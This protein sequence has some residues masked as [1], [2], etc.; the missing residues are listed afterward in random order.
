M[1]KKGPKWYS[2]DPPVRNDGS[3]KKFLFTDVF[4]KIKKFKTLNL[5]FLKRMGEVFTS[6]KTLNKTDHY[7][8]NYES[9]NLLFCFSKFCIG[10]P[11]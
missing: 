2:Y 5:F 8:Q 1:S 7:L 4:G 10:K 3:L 11:N 9:S 6:L